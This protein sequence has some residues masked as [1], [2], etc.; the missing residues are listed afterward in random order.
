M[1]TVKEIF[2]YLCEFAPLEK[3]MDFD[4]AGF[5]VGRQDAEVKKVLLSLDVTPDVVEEAAEGGYELIISHHPVIFNALKSVTDEKLMRLVENRIAVISMHTNLDITEGGVND[6]LLSLLGAERDGYFDDDGCGRTGHYDSPLSLTEFLELCR[7][8]LYA[9]GLRY[10]DAGRPVKKIAVLGGAGGSELKAAAEKGCDTYLTSDI[11]YHEF[12]SAQELGVNLIDGDHFGT[13][14]PV[15]DMLCQRL[16]AR[17]PD[18]VFH[19]SDRHGAV[20]KF[21]C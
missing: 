3:Q 16:S 5:L 8:K 9:N 6:V 10:Y 4:N 13:E 11:R 19:K 1:Q 17:F 21:F 15:I 2:E 20:I 14:N 18:T 7:N 12:L